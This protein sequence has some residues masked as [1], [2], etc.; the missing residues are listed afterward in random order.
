[1]KLQKKEKNDKSYDYDLDK[2]CNEK[3]VILALV[4]YRDFFEE[5]LNLMKKNEIID[6]LVGISYGEVDD[7]IKASS[8]YNHNHSIK[9]SKLIKMMLK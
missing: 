7:K 6:Y 8:E 4:F 3:F 1:M 2:I 5:M 9:D